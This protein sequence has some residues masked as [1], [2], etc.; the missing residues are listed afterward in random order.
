M[1]TMVATPC[2][3]F[4]LSWY[5]NSNATN[6]LTS[7]T[8][9]L[10]NKMNYNDNEQIHVGAKQVCQFIILVLLFSLNSVLESF[11]KQLLHVPSITKNLIIVSKFATDNDV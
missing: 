5:L 3:V 9:N 11:L 2:I 7:D 1:S 4:D 10:M 8:N 6:H